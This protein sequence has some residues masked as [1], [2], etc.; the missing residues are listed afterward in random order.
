[1]NPSPYSGRAGAEYH[2][3]R[4]VP[5]KGEF[6]IGQLRA[7]KFQP[8]IKGTEKVLEYGV[9]FGWNLMHLRCGD[10]VGYDICDSLEAS[11]R[12][13]GICFTTTLDEF[14]PASFGV[15]ICHHTL[16]HLLD[17]SA[18]LTTM[19]NLLSE[20]GTLLLN[21]PYEVQKT[22][23]YE[24]QSDARHLYAWTP[25]TLTNLVSYLGFDVSFAEIVRFRFDRAAAIAAVRL[26]LG[27][28]GFRFLRR[29]GLLLLPEFEIRLLALKSNE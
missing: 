13:K 5:P 8:Y 10:K 17:P 26:R 6:L 1:M 19:R 24:P 22:R 23:R 29:V 9:G 15:V 28:F 12:R 7:E 16:E 21:V 3:R 2:S 20:R 18:A 25:R 14:A 11:V 4:M 27:R